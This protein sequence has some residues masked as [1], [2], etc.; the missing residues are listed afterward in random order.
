MA[1]YIFR[2]PY[3]LEGPSGG[4][5][6]FYFATLRKGV[7]IAKSGG[8]YSRVRYVVDSTIAEY[9]EFY[10]GGCQHVV[11]D[12][13]KAELIAGGIGVTEANFTAQ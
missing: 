9:E 12:A 3:V 6:L 10:A 2:P 5:R 4:H 13:T 1:T 7:S 11:N 8:V